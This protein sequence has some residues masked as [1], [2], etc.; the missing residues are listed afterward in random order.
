MMIDLPVTIDFDAQ[1]TGRPKNPRT[2]TLRFD[3][4][5]TDAPAQVTDH[6]P[7]KDKANW[8]PDK[9][10]V[11]FGLLPSNSYQKIERNA[12]R[13]PYDYCADED[14]GRRLQDEIDAQREADGQFGVGA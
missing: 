5:D 2:F 7:P 8:W 3:L 14:E 9:D 1:T 10:G 4:D 11:I 12:R 6:Y 13:Y